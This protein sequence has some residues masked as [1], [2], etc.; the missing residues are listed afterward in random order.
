MKI[1]V[2]MS[3]NFGL[4]VD[5]N[6][7]FQMPE[8][9][10]N[11]QLN[12]YGIFFVEYFQ[13][14]TLTFVTSHDIYWVAGVEYHVNNRPFQIKGSSRENNSMACAQNKTRS[15]RYF[16]RYFLYSNLVSWPN[17]RLNY[18]ESDAFNIR[19]SN[20]CRAVM[21]ILFCASS[22][23]FWTKHISCWGDTVCC[24]FATLQTQSL[25]AK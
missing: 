24:I 1:G 5:S 22:F 4:V 3:S 23:L 17:L 12:D 14:M 13:L 6:R 20:V 8:I 18:P 16:F 9:V 7:I 11:F 25:R 15:S 19:S 21:M 2:W 10:S